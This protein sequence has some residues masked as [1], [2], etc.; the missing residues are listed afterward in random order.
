MLNLQD[1]DLLRQACLINGEWVGAD[2]GAADV[3]TN[4]AD[5]NEIGH[6]PRLGEAET[7]RAIDAA[8]NAMREWRGRT[9]K[10]RGVI[11]PLARSDA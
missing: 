1:K 2:D 11:A 3:V 7:L 6:V 5:G 9:A 8:D 4:P 10:E